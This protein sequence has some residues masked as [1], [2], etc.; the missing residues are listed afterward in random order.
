MDGQVVRVNQSQ[1]AD[2]LGVT[3]Q[4]VSHW[5]SGATHPS[6]RALRQLANITQIPY[7]D[8]TAALLLDKGYIEHPG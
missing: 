1:F 6:P 2:A 4:T 3:R 8:L 7:N 5:K